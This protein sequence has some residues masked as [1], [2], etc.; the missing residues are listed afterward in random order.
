MTNAIKFLK[1]SAA[2]FAL[3]FTYAA[4]HFALFIYG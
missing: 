4:A 1:Y 2:F 3:A